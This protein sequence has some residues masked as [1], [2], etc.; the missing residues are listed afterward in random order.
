MTFLGVLVQKSSVL[1]IAQIKTYL[2]GPEDERVEEEVF[3]FD[4]FASFCSKTLS[5]ANHDFFILSQ[6]SVQ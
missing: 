3:L 5:E 4:S 1:M 2:S 6:V